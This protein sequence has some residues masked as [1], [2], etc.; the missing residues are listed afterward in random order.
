MGVNTNEQLVDFT[1]LNG[2]TQ[3]GY[4]PKPSQTVG[5][6]SL[7]TREKQKQNNLLAS[8]IVPPEIHSRSLDR[9]FGDWKYKRSEHKIIVIKNTT[10]LHMQ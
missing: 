6:Y 9:E 3:E 4:K 1:K 8:A 10:R 5:V 7:K 2:T